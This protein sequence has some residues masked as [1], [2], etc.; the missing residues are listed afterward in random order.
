MSN[1]AVLTWVGSS[2]HWRGRRWEN[3]GQ[4]MKQWQGYPHKWRTIG[5]VRV[6][7]LRPF[8]GCSFHC[9]MNVQD[10][11]ACRNI[12]QKR[13]LLHRQLFAR[14]LLL[15][16]IP[17]EWFL[18][19][20]PSLSPPPLP[21]LSVKDEVFKTR[22]NPVIMLSSSLAYLFT[23]LVILWTK[24]II[25]LQLTHQVI[26][27]FCVLSILGL[28]PH[29]KCEMSVFMGQ[30]LRRVRIAVRILCISWHAGHP[31]KAM[32]YITCRVMSF[33]PWQASCVPL[34]GLSRLHSAISLI[35][36]IPSMSPLPLLFICSIAACHIV[37]FSFFSLFLFSIFFSRSLSLSLL[38]TLPGLPP[39]ILIVYPSLCTFSASWCSVP[40]SAT[41]H[42]SAMIQKPHINTGISPRDY[43]SVA[44]LPGR[45]LLCNLHSPM[46][47]VGLGKRGFGGVWGLIGF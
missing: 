2:F 31:P 30:L 43:L 18:S 36:S 25:A 44:C 6:H 14:M 28:M 41:T 10:S 13:E 38:I 26:N 16:S 22:T 40:Q 3:Q 5:R 4:V 19:V 7:S 12:L 29:F 42:C 9:Y 1:S 47:R 23:F 24:A 8:V 32:K 46:N 15:K 33:R 17:L 37:E 45:V 21:C 35:L 20:S 39:F 34:R 27:S 11:G